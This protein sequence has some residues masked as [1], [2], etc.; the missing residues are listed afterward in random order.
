MF[1]DAIKYAQKMPF[2]GVFSKRW[3]KKGEE[4]EEK[5]LIH[6]GSWVMATNV[7]RDSL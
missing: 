7:K 3:V 2:F 5:I 6:F 1:C 4:N